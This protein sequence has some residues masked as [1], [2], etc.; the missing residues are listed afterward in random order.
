MRHALFLI[1]ILALITPP[2][3][4]AKKGGGG[5]NTPGNA[6]S[7]AGKSFEEVDK[8]GDGFVSIGEWNTAHVGKSA[9]YY[10]KDKDGDKKLNKAEFG[11]SSG[12]AAKKKK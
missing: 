6:N 3:M 2:A 4:A 5:K 1:V 10:K 8:N 11:G 7:G 9:D 12:G